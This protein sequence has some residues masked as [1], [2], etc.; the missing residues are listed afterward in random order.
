M[1]HFGS[2][3]NTNVLYG[4]TEKNQSSWWLYMSETQNVSENVVNRT[5]VHEPELRLFG[6][7]YK[8]RA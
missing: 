1:L 4:F 2:Y 3:G 8:R 7:F 6:L 5:D